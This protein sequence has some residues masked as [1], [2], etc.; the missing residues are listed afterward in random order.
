MK[1][2]V[3]QINTVAVNGST[4]RIAE[5]IGDAAIA[6]GYESYIAYGRGRPVK[7]SS[8]LIKIGNDLS[9]LN[10]ILQTRCFDKQGLCS[11]LATKKLIKEIERIKPTIVH[12]HNLH[13]NYLNY[14]VL[15]DYLAANDISVVWTI[16]DCWPVTGHCVHFTA[17]NCEKW[18]YGCEKCPRLEGYPKSIFLDRSKQNYIDK[19]K[20]FTSLKSMTIIPV[21][22]WLEGVLESFLGHYNIKYIY[23]GIDVEKFYP[24][25]HAISEIRA[26][27]GLNNKFVILGVA[28]GW[29][30]DNGLYDFIELRKLL[31]GEYAIVLVGVTPSLKSK[32]PNGIIG[33]ERTDSVDELAAIYSCADIFINGSKEETF[34]LVTAESMACGTPVIVYNSTACA[35]IV[36]ADTG[37]IVEPGDLHAVISAINKH[38]SLPGEDKD[39]MSVRCSEYVRANFRKE[40]K[41]HEYVNLY[42]QII[43]SKS[44]FIT[45]KK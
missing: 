4:G 21:S 38:H 25:K 32:L 45:D 37:Y 9:V 3:L 13:G 10:H 22:Q 27:Y 26:K 2:I 29:S 34:G 41:Y 23:N 1:R 20:A 12:L 15:F 31:S 16:H 44:N 43:A 5:G 39:K 35:E 28:T 33:I 24:R 11:S 42:D 6:R 40:D 30:K 8:S 36:T 19:K 7:S 17:V 14:N 18:K